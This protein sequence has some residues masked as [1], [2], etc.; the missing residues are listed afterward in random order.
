MYSCSSYFPVCPHFPLWRLR[1]TGTCVWL[2]GWLS[3]SVLDSGFVRCSC[4]IEAKL[5]YMATRTSLTPT[6]GCR[7]YPSVYFNML[8]QPFFRTPHLVKINYKKYSWFA[9]AGLGFSKMRTILMLIL[10]TLLSKSP[11]QKC[12]CINQMPVIFYESFCLVWHVMSWTTLTYVDSSNP[13]LEEYIAD[14]EITH[15]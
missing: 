4:R 6:I 15:W 11:R 10:F 14:R 13:D 8:F 2:V 12:C 1:I 5:G 3:E 7:L 9:D